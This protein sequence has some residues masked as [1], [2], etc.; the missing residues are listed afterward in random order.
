MRTSKTILALLLVLALTLGCFVASLPASAQI[1]V[2]DEEHIISYPD[3]GF[4]DGSEDDL[5]LRFDFNDYADGSITDTTG[6]IT[7]TS[8]NGTT[9]GLNDDDTAMVFTGTK[10]TF[11]WSADDYNPLLLCQ[12]GLTMTMWVKADSIGNWNHLFNFGNAKN[13]KGGESSGFTGNFVFFQESDSGT[14]H[15]NTSYSEDNSAHTS[16]RYVSTFGSNYLNTWKMLTVTE[17]G[18]GNYSVYEDNRLVESFQLEYSMYEIAAHCVAI[19]EQST[20]YSLFAPQDNLWETDPGYK[21]AVQSFSL[22]GSVK[23]ADEIAAMYNAAMDVDTT[24]V[25]NVQQLITQAATQE[26]GSDAQRDSYAVAAAAYNALN[27]L[28]K[29][30]VSNSAKL[31]EIKADYIAV[32][33]NILYFGFNGDYSELFGRATINS[34][35]GHDTLTDSYLLLDGQKTS[36]WK[37]TGAMYRRDYAIF[38]Q[39]KDAITIEMLVNPVSD[40]QSNTN[41]FSFTYGNERNFKLMANADGKLL[42]Q[43]INIDSGIS[44]N[45]TEIGAA[46]AVNEWSTLSLVQSVEEE[47]VTTKIYV[48]GKPVYSTEEIPALYTLERTGTSDDCFF[49]GSADYDDYTFPG[50]IDYFAVYNYAKTYPADYSDLD[51]AIAAGN[52]LDSSRYESTTYNAMLAALD[53]AKQVSR[54]L[55]AEEQEVVDAA[56]QAL[57]DAFA[58]LIS[59]YSNYDA[60]DAAVEAAEALQQDLYTADSLAALAT[61][62][63]DAKAVDRNLTADQQSQVDAATKA[64]TDAISALVYKPADYTA[65]NAAVS[66]AEE[67]LATT[68]EYTPESLAWLQ[69]V[70][71]RY[72]KG[73]DLTILDQT[74]LDTATVEINKAIAEL[75]PALADY[76]N[77]KAAMAA[78][79]EALQSEGLYNEDSLEQLLS[80]VTA[81]TL[82]DN[83]DKTHQDELDAAAAAIQAALE[84][85]VEILT[86]IPG[87]MNEDGKLSVTDVVLLRKAI[88]NDTAV[89]EV[90]MG[91]MNGDGNL[92]VTDVVLLR[93]AILAQGN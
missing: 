71:S 12:D 13:L 42:I 66:A 68:G 62:V 87:D 72:T 18:Q 25:E 49:I 74:E 39:A 44:L 15:I 36:F 93:K 24:A 5:L 20:N 60:L 63:A 55:S 1:V 35:Q 56:L 26:S 73:S 43:V 21:G 84:D 38:S 3:T 82:D 90:P 28:E 41:L 65:Y 22:Y 10:Q 86:F 89:A 7:V 85:L 61:A 23:S 78:A 83:L 8:T 11:I 53:A 17:D 57:N 76:T 91:D 58:Q 34:Y 70:L 4:G 30:L 31:D 16:D 52:A 54:D 9:A 37:K 88:L 79:Q 64:V 47:T 6:N 80:V 48:N 81:N 67:A 69:D 29:T 92:S 40:Y 32:T 59:L 77:Y 50:Y 19:N 51:A 46:P 2:D 33:G 27:S 14:L 45:L 75:Q